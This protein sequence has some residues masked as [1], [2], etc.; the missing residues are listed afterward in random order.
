MK[1]AV[2]IS[3]SMVVVSVAVSS[4]ERCSEHASPHERASAGQCAS[5]HDEAPRH[6]LETEWD[7]GHGHVGPEIAGRCRTCHEPRTCVACHEQSPASHTAGFLRPVGDGAEAGLHT[8]LGDAHPAA[9]VVCHGTPN[10]ECGG[11]H[12]PEE[13]RAWVQDAEEDLDRWRDL[14]EER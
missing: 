14:L 8:V 7:V 12:R 6:H 13:T 1:R 11:C 2:I 3:A 4:V 5:C 10:A 9:C